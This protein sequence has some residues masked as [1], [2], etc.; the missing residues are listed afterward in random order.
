MIIGDFRKRISYFFD[1]EI[2]SFSFG[3]NNLLRPVR[4]A[5]VTHLLYN[6]C[7]DQY[8]SIRRPRQISF[9]EMLNFHTR[10]YI[11]FLKNVDKFRRNEW[12]KY[13]IR[14]NIG[15]FLDADCPSLDGLLEYN[16]IYCGGTSDGADLICRKEVETAINW[17]GGMHHAKKRKAVGFCYINDIVLSIFE[18]LKVFTRVLY[19]DIDIHH[20]D[21]VEEAFYSYD[22]V[23][24]ISFHKSGNFFPRTGHLNDGG[25]SVGKYYSVNVPLRN[26][27]S[28]WGYH[29]I[30]ELIIDSIVSKFHPEVIVVCAGADSLS[31]DLLG[32]FNI[33]IFCHSKCLKFLAKFNSP[34][35]VLGGGGY[36]ARNVAYCWIIET[37]LIVGREFVEHFPKNEEWFIKMRS[38]YPL[39]SFAFDANELIFYENLSNKVLM[40][41]GKISYVP[42]ITFCNVILPTKEHE[43]L[44]D[45]DHEICGGGPLYHDRK[46]TF[47]NEFETE[48]E[49]IS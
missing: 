18:L 30:F 13:G 24:T 45:E 14:F 37:S 47:I 23:M 41:I 11:E 35:L 36:S 29:Y 49:C 5:I 31:N 26:G 15:P 33:T 8:L 17:S 16:K 48:S 21:G 44:L 38:L 28:D 20:G 43:E 19:V 34:M 4:A 10:D 6:Y 32:C 12:V 7:L 3:A 22:R 42:C 40:K 39:F 25:V 46:L 1:G 9:V 2:G 27:V